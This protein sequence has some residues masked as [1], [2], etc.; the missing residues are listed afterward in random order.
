M[1]FGGGVIPDR[2]IPHLKELGVRAVF[3]PGTSAAEIIAAV[4]RMFQERERE[5]PRASVD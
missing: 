2:D 4:D 1:V 3:T 5:Q